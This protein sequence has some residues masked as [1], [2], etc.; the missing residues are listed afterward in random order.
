MSMNFN[1]Y[2]DLDIATKFVLPINTIVTENPVEGDGNCVF[3]AV[4][5]QIG[6][7]SSEPSILRSRVVQYLLDN[8]DYYKD[9]V[10][11]ENFQEEVSKLSQ[12]GEYKFELA[13]LV[14]DIIAHMLKINIVVIENGNF[15]VQW[16]KSHGDHTLPTIYISKG[17]EHY[18]S[19]KVVPPLTLD[20]MDIYT[21]ATNLSRLPTSFRSILNGM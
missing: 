16:G 14:V 19:A 21:K 1:L 18:N 7:K 13:D 15:M 11:V 8:Y 2:V 10:V 9:F 5:A 4:H 17:G 3:S 12:N 6:S 20:V